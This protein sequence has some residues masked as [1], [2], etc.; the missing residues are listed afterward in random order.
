[1]GRIALLY[2]MNHASG[3][4]LRERHSSGADTAGLGGRV[5]GGRHT[6][7]LWHLPMGDALVP[8]RVGEYTSW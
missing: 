4:R 6:P 8:V 3:D 7:S 2:A 1:V 5:G